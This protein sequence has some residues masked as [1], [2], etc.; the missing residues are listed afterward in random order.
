VVVNYLIWVLRI[1]VRSSEITASA[2]N[3]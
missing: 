2:L 3:C 1:K